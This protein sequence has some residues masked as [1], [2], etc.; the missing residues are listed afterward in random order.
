MLSQKSVNL[1]RDNGYVACLA[2]DNSTTNTHNAKRFPNM[3]DGIVY[4]FYKESEL[5][6]LSTTSDKL[7]DMGIR[8]E[9]THF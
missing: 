7:C 9:V 4:Q 8:I 6:I 2:F 3:R 5:T 1:A